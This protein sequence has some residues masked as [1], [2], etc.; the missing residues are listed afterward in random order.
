[1]HADVE[2]QDARDAAALYDVLETELV[3]RFFDRDAGGLPRAWIETMKASIESV[4]P[5]FSAHRMVRDY[6]QDVYLPAARRR[7]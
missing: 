1:M 6:A 3:P 2:T 7:G 4:V 5:A